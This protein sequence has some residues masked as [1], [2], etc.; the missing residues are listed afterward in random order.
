MRWTPDSHVSIPDVR[1]TVLAGVERGGGR[2][3][4]GRGREDVPVAV[5]VPAERRHRGER[6]VGGTRTRVRLH[7][8]R[9]VRV[10]RHHADLVV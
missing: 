5:R 4:S 7:E 9:A 6:D 1:R 2:E 8:G 10:E 3:T